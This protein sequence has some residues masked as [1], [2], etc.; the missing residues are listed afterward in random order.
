MFI[1]LTIAASLALAHEI[2]RRS[3]AAALPSLQQLAFD[4]GLASLLWVSSAAVL[5]AVHL[6]IPAIVVLRGVLFGVL[7]IVLFWRRRR[8]STKDSLH[9]PGAGWL[10][11][12]LP[13]VL[14][15][16]FVLWRGALLPPLNHDAMSYHMP[17]AVFFARAGGFERLALEWREAKLPVNYE[18]LLA[19]AIAGS[20]NDRTTDWISTWFYIGFIVVSVALADRWS[21][22]SAPAA[23]TIALLTAAVPVALLQSG[24]H[25]NDLMTAFF[26]ASA[27]LWAGCWYSGR[28]RLSLMLTIASVAAAMGTKPQ[29]LTLA[30]MLAPVVA[31]PLWA[32]SR[33][34]VP[35]LGRIAAVAA[36][37]IA[38][39][40]L[41]GCWTYVINPLNTT[42][43]SVVMYGDWANLW[44]APYVLLAAPFARDPNQLYVPWEAHPWFW[45]RYEL[46]FSDLGVP[47]AL[48]AIALPFVIAMLRPALRSE[49]VV[50]T[51][52]AGATFVLMLPVIFEPHGFFAISLPRYVLFIVPVVLAWT[53]PPLMR[54]RRAIDGFIV[55]AAAIWFTASA[56][57][58]GMNDRFAPIEYVDWMRTHPGSRVGSVD[59]FRA[60]FTADRLAGP[61]DTI[62]V[63]A[64]YGTWI[65]PLFGR[66]LSRPVELLP[67]G[68]GP[69]QIPPDARYVVIDRAFDAI[70]TG[71]NFRDLSESQRYLMHGA[72]KPEDY[73]LFHELLSDPRFELVYRDGRF[74]QAV[75]RRR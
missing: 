69:A 56:V 53:V 73:R 18:I 8:L 67:D 45:K 15:V 5:A 58:N 32:K 22:L 2:G 75:F 42:T 57:D 61:R 19:D 72:K 41:F 70:W 24:E 52:A 21:P 29:A 44:Q 74:N 9:V 17:K 6:L 50:V 25:K 12:L 43:K 63:E 33:R 36:G 34:V 14:W 47:F 54:G 10:I 27:L 49:R 46:F 23:V 31:W 1:V 71:Q 66:D 13:L 38:A 35:F 68:A 51:A 59:E 37:S 48:C 28:D 30:A 65:D 40:L 3:A 26:M 20:G 16:G 4:A 62:A 60:A 64:A 11:A 7:A 55:A 39:A